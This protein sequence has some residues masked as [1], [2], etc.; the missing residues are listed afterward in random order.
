MKDKKDLTVQ[1]FQ[2]FKSVLEKAGSSQYIDFFTLMFNTGLRTSDV[3]GL[4][5]ADIDYKSNSISIDKGN[6]N[7]NPSIVALNDECMQVLRRLHDKYPNGVFVFQS[8]KS[9]NQK[10]KPPASIS[11]QVVSKAFKTASDITSLPITPN[12]LR[13]YYANQLFST[14]FLQK[15]DPKYLSLFMG[16]TPCTMTKHYVNNC[17]IENSEAHN[18]L[19]APKADMNNREPEVIEYLL[20]GGS[21]NENYNLDDICQKYGISENDL[22][23]TLKTIKILKKNI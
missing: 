23:I 17:H 11:R 18:C 3:L 9:M 22:T 5:F 6:Q 10:N 20:N 8:R 4:K 15:S 1:D 14:K 12:A 7:L 16:H 2:N 13:H 21:L 19:S